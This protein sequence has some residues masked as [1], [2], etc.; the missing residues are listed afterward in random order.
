MKAH[1][2]TLDTCKIIAGQYIVL[3]GIS[4]IFPNNQPL[5]IRVMSLQSFYL[6]LIDQEKVR[7]IDAQAAQFVYKTED[8]VHFEVKQIRDLA[9]YLAQ[10]LADYMTPQMAKNHPSVDLK[11]TKSGNWLEVKK[12]GNGEAKIKGGYSIETTLTLDD[13]HKVIENLKPFCKEEILMGHK[14]LNQQKTHFEQISDQLVNQA[15]DCRAAILSL[16]LPDSTNQHGKSSA[17]IFGR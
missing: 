12:S 10:L 15:R 9:L 6:R 2:E 17:T 11:N 13:I 5:Q 8:S 14:E 16:T 7:T 3:M 4:R 1:E